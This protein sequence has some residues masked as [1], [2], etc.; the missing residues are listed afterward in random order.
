MER[1]CSKH[2]QRCQRTDSRYRHQQKSH[3]CRGN[4]DNV[5]RNYYPVGV[6][7][8]RS[9]MHRRQPVGYE[10]SRHRKPTN[11]YH[12]TNHNCH[13]KQY[14]DSPYRYR[15][16]TSSGD[17]S[18]YTSTSSSES[19]E[20]MPRYSGGGGHYKRRGRRTPSPVTGRSSR[21]SSDDSNFTPLNYGTPGCPGC[22][23]QQ[24]WAQGYAPPMGGGQAP[25]PA[26]GGWKQ[27]PAQPYGQPAPAGQQ[28]PQQPQNKPPPPEL[29]EL[30]KN[31]FKGI[32]EFSK[33]LRNQ[34]WLGDIDYLRR[35]RNVK[36]GHKPETLEKH[37]QESNRRDWVPIY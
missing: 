29:E 25:P 16:D 23:Q 37:R 8:R 10:E 34:Q 32:K 6:D 4:S 35:S 36:H 26:Q 24:Q 19:Y 14:Y 20:R 12:N 11:H 13:H 5:A 7:H 9:S 22:Q 2:H 30:R 17:T 28:P 3:N 33:S 15:R 18:S 1:S 21:R 31:V 27:V